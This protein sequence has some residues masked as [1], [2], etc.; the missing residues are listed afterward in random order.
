MGKPLSS[1]CQHISIHHNLSHCHYS[2]GFEEK[3]PKKLTIV[4]FMELEKEMLVSF[5]EFQSSQGWSFG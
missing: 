2:L 4:S 3:F 1:C 5:T